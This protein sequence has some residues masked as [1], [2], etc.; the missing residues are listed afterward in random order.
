MRLSELRQRW[1]A[2]EHLIDLQRECQGSAEDAMRQE[3]RA[4]IEC[5][6]ASVAQIQSQADKLDRAALRELEQGPVS[7]WVNGYRS[8]LGM[9]FA[10]SAYI[11]GTLYNW[12]SA[13]ISQSREPEES[14]DPESKGAGPASAAGT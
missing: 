4:A 1:L 13:R 14:R 11:L 7:D 5:V 12:I 2:G 6:N 9:G 8:G 10:Q 3:L